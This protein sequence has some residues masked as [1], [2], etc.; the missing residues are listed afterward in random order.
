[1]QLQA[2]ASSLSLAR[3]PGFSGLVH[4][5][6]PK[7]RL[8]GAAA[9]VEA[10]SAASRRSKMVATGIAVGLNKGHIVTKRDVA[11]KPSRRKG[12][13]DEVLLD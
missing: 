7:S 5:L 10:L 9:R 6:Q 8:Q 12:V 11:P 13:G 1:M 4:Q 2:R 3:A